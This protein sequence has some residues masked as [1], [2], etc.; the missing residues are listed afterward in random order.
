MRFL[1]HG[2]KWWI[3]DDDVELFSINAVEDI[4][5]HIFNFVRKSI[6]FC[7]ER[8][9]VPDTR[10]NV[11]GGGAGAVGWTAGRSGSGEDADAGRTEGERAKGGAGAVVEKEKKP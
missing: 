5:M 2:D 4:T 7:I 10:I 11:G 6:Q 9:I 8:K 3:A 1:W